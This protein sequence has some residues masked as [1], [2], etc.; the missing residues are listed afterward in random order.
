M[1][2]FCFTIVFSFTLKYLDLKTIYCNLNEGITLSI[3]C[4]ETYLLLQIK[5][6]LK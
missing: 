5:K 2:F 1:Y 4:F 3:A 6:I